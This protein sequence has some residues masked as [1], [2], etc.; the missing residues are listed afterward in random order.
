MFRLFLVV[1][2]NGLLD[3]APSLF[4]CKSNGFPLLLNLFDAADPD[5]RNTA[6]AITMHLLKHGNT[7]TL[8]HIHDVNWSLVLDACC[9]EFIRLN[10]HSKLAPLMSSD[11][12]EIL[13]K[14]LHITWSLVH[15]EQGRSIA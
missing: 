5:V 11:Y 4:L 10:G 1:H 13:D 9:Q 7:D 6:L 2:S 8:L 14:V 3:M 12:S 15:G